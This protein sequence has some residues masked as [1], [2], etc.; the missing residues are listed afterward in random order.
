MHFETRG[1]TSTTIGKALFINQDP[2]IYGTF[3]EIG[4]GQEVARFFFQAGRASQTVAK[5]ISAYDMIY[6]DEIYGKEKN[7]R[8]VCE[9]RLN[10]ML[11]KEF[12]LLQ[13]RLAPVRADKTCFFAYANT[14]ATSS[15]GGQRQC[16]GWMGIR[17]QAQPKGPANDIVIH[18]RLLDAFRLQQQEAIGI[19]GVNL[20]ASAFL[21]RSSQDTL[22]TSLTDN[23]KAGRI[24]IDM[25][26]LEGP[27]FAQIDQRA[28]NIELVHRNLTEAVLF[29][30]KAQIQTVSDYVFGKSIFVQRGAFKPLHRTNQEIIE[31]GFEQF[32][33]EPFVKPES[34]K[35]ILEMT[36]ALEK[37]LEKG[38]H[39]TFLDRIDTI[40]SLGLPVFVSRFNLF[41]ELKR[42]LRRFTQ[43]PVGIAVSASYLENIFDGRHYQNLEGGLLE[44]LGKLFDEKTKLFV[45]P[46]KD[47]KVCLTTEQFRPE[48]EYLK[49][50]QYFLER[51]Q[52]V[53]IAGC[54]SV[55]DT[56]HSE[57]VKALIAKGDAAWEKLVP[58]Q[59]AEAIKKKS[60]F[61]YTS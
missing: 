47:Q 7:G 26:R 4:A 2:S 29:D 13:K 41:F 31:H 19:L 58:E 32:T 60:L 17:F 9:S 6:S 10:K 5:T 33:K 15:E 52:I 22:L 35:V 42:F 11:D 57:D 46:Y 45:Y 37:S 14:V 3:A 27:E 16:H 12:S 50:Y 8:Y 51:Q 40:S 59:V 30:E 44:G 43:L 18:M 48:K 1:G 28:L 55:N 21:S 25:I 61:G 20:V 54:D 49:I 38:F 34:A 23:L 53:D 39:K 56:I 36:L 24:A